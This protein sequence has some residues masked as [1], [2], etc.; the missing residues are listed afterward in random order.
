MKEIN[1]ERMDLNV[2]W[3]EIKAVEEQPF[4]FPVVFSPRLIDFQ[5]LQDFYLKPGKFIGARCYDAFRM[6]MIKSDGSAMPAH[7]RCY[8]IE[9]GNLYQQSLKD[10]WRSEAIRRFR[11]TLTAAG[12]LLPACARCCS[13][14]ST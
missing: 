10:I 11:K 2:L 8:K 4:P 1:I 5:A 6:L 3:R 14:F 12:G 7:S 13:A 9:A